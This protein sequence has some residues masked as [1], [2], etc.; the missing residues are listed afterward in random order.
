MATVTDAAKAA[1]QG[2][3]V[4]LA[5]G[6]G[7]SKDPDA[8]IVNWD[9]TEP[10]GATHVRNWTPQLVGKGLFWDEPIPNTQITDRKTHRLRAFRFA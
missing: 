8:A 7:G 4:V 5:S 6:H 9:P 10:P 1:G 2:G 3:V